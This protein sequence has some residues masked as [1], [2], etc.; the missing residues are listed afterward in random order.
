MMLMLCGMCVTDQASKLLFV[1]CYVRRG[2]KNEVRKYCNG[3]M[4]IIIGKIKSWVAC[5][6]AFVR[7]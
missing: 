4:M 7:E 5:V 3:R 2:C 1:R 6:R